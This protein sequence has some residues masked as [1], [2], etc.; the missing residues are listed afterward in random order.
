M[1]CCCLRVLDI[2][3]I[4]PLYKYWYQDYLCMEVGLL[5]NTQC[6]TPLRAIIGCRP[7]PEIGGTVIIQY[8][9]YIKKY[10]I[11][12]ISNWLSN[13][14]IVIQYLWKLR[15][16]NVDIL[17]TSC[18]TWWLSCYVMLCKHCIQWMQ[19]SKWVKKWARSE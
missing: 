1:I 10:T 4:E 17:F 9:T 19:V 16:A 3:W 8:I 14:T 11:Q 15:Y 18:V 13:I 2:T 12:W 5:G 7:V 6:F